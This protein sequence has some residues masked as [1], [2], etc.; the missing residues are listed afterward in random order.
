MQSKVKSCLKYRPSATDDNAAATD[1]EDDGFGSYGEAGA[2]SGE[3]GPGSG[4]NDIDSIHMSAKSVRK[5][6]HPSVTGGRSKTRQV[7][8][9][10]SLV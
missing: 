9:A 2:G 10:T 3:P 6:R 7:L 4:H 5:P 8:S 1:G